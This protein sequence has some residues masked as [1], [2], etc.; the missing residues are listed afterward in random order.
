M[1]KQQIHESYKRNKEDLLLTCKRCQST[2]IIGINGHT[3]DCFSLV[4]GGKEYNGYVV[5][6]MNI[7]DGGDDV[8]FKYCADCGQIQ[9]EFPIKEKTIQDEIREGL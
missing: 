7:G 9:G 8:E 4:Y 6:N 5:A 1:P 2:R 3:S